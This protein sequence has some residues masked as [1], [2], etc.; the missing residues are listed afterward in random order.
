MKKTL[1]ALLVIVLVVAIVIGA[2]AG[3]TYYRKGNKTVDVYSVS[4]LNLGY[5]ENTT[6]SE[7]VV[8]NNASQSIYVTDGQKVIDVYVTEGQ[9]VSEGDP[10]MAY[11]VTSL[12]LSVAMKKLQ[13]ESFQN[14]YDTGMAKLNV[15]KNTTP[16]PDT[17]A[18]PS[19]V[20]T[21][22]TEGDGS[23]TAGNSTMAG[24]SESAN[25]TII[26]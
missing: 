21:E 15:L 26:E 24:S 7:G 11:D 8:K 25:I 2:V 20:P 9:E 19:E 22:S 17:L 5:Y 13:I 14:E 6:T 12:E 4:M 16:I 23:T 18:S 1:K 3:V 10:L